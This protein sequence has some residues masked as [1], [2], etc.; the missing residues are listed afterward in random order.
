MSL[1]WLGASYWE[2]RRALRWWSGRQTAQLWHESDRIHDE[3]LQK[4][5]IVRRELELS[6]LNE[7]ESQ[8][9]KYRDWLTQ[10][11]QVHSSLEALSNQ[12]YPPYLEESLPLAIQAMLRSWTLRYPLTLNTEL[13]LHW[14][15]ESPEHSQTLL[16]LLSE[17][18]RFALLEQL[19]LEVLTQTLLWVRLSSTDRYA[20]LTVRITYPDMKTA[21]AIESKRLSQEQRYLSRAFECLNSGRFFYCENGTI[22]QWRFRWNLLK[23]EVKPEK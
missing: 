22:T 15:S 7:P 3:L 5:F 16:R 18:L 8:S 17:V 2:M 13:P 20:E 4:I 23:H 1:I 11:E 21:K 9:G 12:L 19:S 6:I 10:V 14:G